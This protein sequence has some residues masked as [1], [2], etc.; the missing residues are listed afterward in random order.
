MI[1]GISNGTS[2]NYLEQVEVF[3]ENKTCA[4][5]MI[6]VVENSLL[7]HVHVTVDHSLTPRLVIMYHFYTER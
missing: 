5:L 2:M 4:A 6:S 1:M 7:M 3:R